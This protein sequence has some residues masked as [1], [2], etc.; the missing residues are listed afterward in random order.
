MNE[1]RHGETGEVTVQTSPAS[2]SSAFSV[3]VER[4]DVLLDKEVAPLAY[5]IWLARGRP[6]GT[7]REDWFE[8]E[9]QLREK[10]GGIPALTPAVDAEQ[11]RE[12]D[13]GRRT[14]GAGPSIRDRM[15]AI[16]RGNQQA[17]RQDA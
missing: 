5:S 1:G 14:R 3:D 13:E 4:R 11:V 15:V 8:A 17:G 10:R 16:G 7:D 6:E 9:R 2:E 12:A